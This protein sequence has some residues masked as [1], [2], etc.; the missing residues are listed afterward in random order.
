[1]EDM[2]YEMENTEVTELEDCEIDT[3]EENEGIDIAKV[4]KFV[5]GGA[6]I[7]GGTAWLF[8]KKIKKLKKKSDLKKLEKL[9]AKYGIALNYEDPDIIECDYEEVDDTEESDD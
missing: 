1:M 9:S 8:R 6:A 4:L 5:I 2:T 3:T 7:A